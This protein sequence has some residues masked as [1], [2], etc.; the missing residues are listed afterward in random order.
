MRV[1][2]SLYY[3]VFDLMLCITRYLSKLNRGS[4][5]TASD[6]DD[7]IVTVPKYKYT[8]SEIS[9][10]KLLIYNHIIMLR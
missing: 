9:G 6:L 7:L 5:S 10:P 3:I 1:F 2:V 8:I 4:T